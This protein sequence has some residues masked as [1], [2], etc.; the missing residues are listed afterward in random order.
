METRNIR[1]DLTLLLVAAIWGLAFVAQRLGMDHLGPFGFNGCRFLLGA[2]SLLPLL[3]IFRPK[4]GA[5]APRALLRGGI[6]AGMILFLGA[7]LQQAGLLWTTAGNAGFITGLYIIIV[8]LLGLLMGHITRLNTWLGGLLAV[9]GLYFLTV[10]TD[11]GASFTINSGDLLVLGS[12][13][14][15]AAHVVV[16]GRLASQLDNLRLAI[17]QFFVCAL[18]S[19]IVALLFEQDTLT[20]SSITQA[21]QPIAYA[22]LLSVGVAYTLQVVAQRHAPAS[23]AAII[24]SLEAVFA[25][26]GGWW[27]LEEDFSNRA[28][29]GCALMLAG[30]IMSQ[31][32]LFR[33]KQTKQINTI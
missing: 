33:R 10:E 9:I 24:M 5:T 28:L 25:A 31:L 13:F 19:F 29:I 27:L 8:P 20:L 12:A 14:F 21:W 2:V 1:A 32:N 18:L 16:I 30:M 26:L 7:S 11:S 4:A 3:L 6:T 23:H 22:G 17:I 15:W